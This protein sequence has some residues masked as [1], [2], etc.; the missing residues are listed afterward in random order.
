MMRVNSEQKKTG[1]S[2]E[3]KTAMRSQNYDMME[4]YDEKFD[5]LKN[6]KRKVLN[7]VLMFKYKPD[8]VFIKQRNNAKHRPAVLQ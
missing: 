1:F 7:F 4:F 5:S 3:M 8:Q 2:R 6:E